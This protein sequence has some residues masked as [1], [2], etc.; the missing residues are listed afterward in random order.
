MCDMVEREWINLEKPEQD[1]GVVLFAAQ[2][3]N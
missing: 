2:I 1:D 3:K